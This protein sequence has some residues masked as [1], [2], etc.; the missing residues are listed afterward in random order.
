MTRLNLK[1][2]IIK[3]LSFNKKNKTLQIKFKRHIKTAK[4][5]NISISILK[6]YIE[7]LKHTKTTEKE[8]TFQSNLKIVYSN[9]KATLKPKFVQS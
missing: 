2:S 7:T 9:F 4:C 3:N 6:D 8:D 1:P 5:I